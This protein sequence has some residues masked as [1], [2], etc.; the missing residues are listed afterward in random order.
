MKILLMTLAL[1]LSGGFAF[2]QS[3]NA[4][5]AQKKL[6]ALKGTYEIKRSV[7]E[8][9]MLPSNLAEIITS[10]RKEKEVSVVKLNATTDLVIYPASAIG[11]KQEDKT[12]AKHD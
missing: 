10:N 3:N 12:G 7:R 2:S 1:M 8:M 11:Q 9:V 6:D 4:T 5:E